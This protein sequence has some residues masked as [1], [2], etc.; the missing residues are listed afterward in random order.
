VEEKSLGRPPDFKHSV[1]ATD[2]RVFSGVFGERRIGVKRLMLVGTIAFLLLT[3]G[4]PA[5][6]ASSSVNWLNHRADPW[7]DSLN[8]DQ[9]SSLKAIAQKHPNWKQ[10]EA[11]CHKFGKDATS[12]YEIRRA[13]TS[14]LR[15]A[16]QTMLTGTLAFANSCGSWA[17]SHGSTK[18]NGVLLILLNQMTSDNHAW[19]TAVDAARSAATPTTTT[20]PPTTTTTTSPQAYKAACPTMPYAQLVKD[21]DAIKGQCVTYQGQVFQYDS[22]TGLQDMLVAVDNDGY[23]D[24]SDNVEVKLPTAAMGNGIYEN[25]IVQFWGPITGTD[26]YQA[27]NNDEITVPVVKAEYL[28]LI[29][30]AQQ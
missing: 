6:A 25:D 24:Y 8:R 20:V 28:T 4:S 27:Q 17:K 7:I 18:A 14:N 9:N 15:S 23:G 11:D 16:W 13:P 26:T 5:G 10:V 21:P 29:S 2:F 19:T 3:A 22:N 1:A 30:S 12:A